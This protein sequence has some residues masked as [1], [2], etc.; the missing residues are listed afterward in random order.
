MKRAKTVFERIAQENRLFSKFAGC[1]SDHTS[2]LNKRRIFRVLFDKNNPPLS[3]A[4]SRNLARQSTAAH[5]T[6][7]EQYFDV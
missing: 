7:R 5:R 1:E 3:F 4:D 6:G 2:E